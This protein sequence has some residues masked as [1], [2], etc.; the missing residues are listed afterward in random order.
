MQVNI[1]RDIGGD[2]EAL[3]KDDKLVAQGHSIDLWQ[4]LEA[5]GFSFLVEEMD[6]EQTGY[7]PPVW[8]TRHEWFKEQTCG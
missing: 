6:L 7:A 5:L 3:Y 1:V 4:A 8:S 2:W